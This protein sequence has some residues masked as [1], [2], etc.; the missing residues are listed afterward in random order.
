MEHIL[1]D[2][3]VFKNYYTSMKAEALLLISTPSDQGGS[4]LE[5]HSDGEVKGFIDEHVRDGY[6]IKEIED[7]LRSVGFSN[8]EARYQYGA[9]GKIAWKLSMMFPMKMLNTSKLFFILLPF[10]YLIT[11]PFSFVLNWLDVSTR[12]SSGSGL[13]VK[14]WK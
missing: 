4:G 1:E 9:P 3:K 7:K 2:V 12:H 6:N 11:Y 8:V 14:A 10:Y 5:E 13:V